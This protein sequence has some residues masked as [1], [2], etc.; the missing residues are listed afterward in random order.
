MEA[1]QLVPHF[2]VN[3]IGGDHVR[4]ADIWQRRNLVLVTIGKSRDHQTSQYISRLQ[5]RAEEFAEAE[6]TLVVTSEP[7]AGLPEPSA[8]VAD[9]WGEIVYESSAELHDVSRL[10]SVDELLDWIRFLRIRCPECPP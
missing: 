8:I 6:T 10:P 3:T 9:Q 7:V 4:Y 1:R 5:S 2:E